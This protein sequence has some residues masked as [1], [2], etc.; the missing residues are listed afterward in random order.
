MYGE[1]FQI[2]NFNGKVYICDN[3]KFLAIKQVFI[4]FFRFEF[5]GVQLKRNELNKK[6]FDYLSW[7]TIKSNKGVTRKILKYLLVPPTPKYFFTFS[8]FNAGSWKA[9]IFTKYFTL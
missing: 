3:F 8:K 6:V 5:V 4:L 1:L 2:W 9:K 7:D